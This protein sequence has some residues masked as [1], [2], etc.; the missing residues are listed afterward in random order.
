MNITMAWQGKEACQNV[1]QHANDNLC[2]DEA[3][4]WSLE[5]GLLREREAMPCRENGQPA[6]RGRGAYKV[7]KIMH[8]CSLTGFYWL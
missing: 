6:G 4:D 1:G 8:E 3:C 5:C 7:V 2:D